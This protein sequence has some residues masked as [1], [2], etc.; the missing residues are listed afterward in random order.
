MERS[1]GSGKGEC[2]LG[3]GG[4]QGLGKLGVRVK[5]EAFSR[6]NFFSGTRS[7][8]QPGSEPVSIFRWAGGHLRV[9]WLCTEDGVACLGLRVITN[10]GS[11]RSSTVAASH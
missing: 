7:S 3:S 5:A 6:N 9:F 10:T 4:K 11:A 2:F 1:C 8:S